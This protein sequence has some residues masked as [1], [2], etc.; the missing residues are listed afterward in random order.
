MYYIGE[1]HSHPDGTTKYSSTDLRARI[2][3]EKEVNIG[4][5]ILLIVGIKHGTLHN[6]TFYYY[7]RGDLLT[8][9]KM[10]DLRDLFHGLQAQMLTRLNV[11]REVISHPGSKGDATEQH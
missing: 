6:H 2:E 1:W 9:K 11:N 10:V 3:I 4:N 8:F 7:K 5:P